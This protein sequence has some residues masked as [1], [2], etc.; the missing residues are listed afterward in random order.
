[1]SDTPSESLI[2]HL[3]ELRTR[4][5]RG[6]IGF[7]LTFICLFPFRNN[8]YA[9]LAQPLIEQLPQGS[10]M[11]AIGIISPVFIPL[12]V[13]MIAAFLVSLPYTLYQIWSFVAPGLY[14]YE[15]RLVAPLVVL[16][17]LL[18]LIGMAFAYF[19]VFPVIFN[20]TAHAAPENVVNMPDIGYYLD[21][22]TMLFLG[23]GVS[24]EVP[25]VVFALARTGMVKIETLKASRAYVIVGAFV[26]AA[27]FT[28]PDVLS[29]FLMAIPICL[30]YEAGIL[31]A[32]LFGE[33]KTESAAS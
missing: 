32:R 29:Q 1:M 26:A 4:L 22:V 5:M 21:I 20:Y 31:A 15:K 33:K 30:L 18:F 2:S 27:I 14:R 6:I 11:Q 12:K 13:A 3:I 7:V 24:F 28:P 8:L 10:H 19:V 16:S 23:F 25:L 17:T 9:A